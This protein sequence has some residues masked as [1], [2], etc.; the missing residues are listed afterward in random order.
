MQA[1]TEEV[2]CV[3]QNHI[4]TFLSILKIVPPKAGLRHMEYLSKTDIR[5]PCAI[6]SRLIRKLVILL[7]LIVVHFIV[8]RLQLTKTLESLRISVCCRKKWFHK[9]YKNR[10]KSHS[11]IDWTLVIIVVMVSRLSQRFQERHPKI[12]FNWSSSKRF[13][14]SWTKL[15]TKSYK[16]TRK[17]C[18]WFEQSVIERKVRD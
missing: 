13:W 4:F 12:T 16:K 10:G 5:S 6:T 15:T 14:M 8:E 7:F 1:P 9:K 18:N 2:L 17:W 11:R 3:F